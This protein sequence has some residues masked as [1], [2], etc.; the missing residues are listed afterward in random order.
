MSNPPFPRPRR[1]APRPPAEVPAQVATLTR[2][3]VL[4]EPD[5]P[6]GDEQAAHALVADHA[7][8]RVGDR[9][10]LDRRSRSLVALATLVGRSDDELLADQVRAARSHGLT[11]PEIEEALLQTAVH[12]G[13]ADAAT[14]VRIARAALEEERP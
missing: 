5:D 2:H 3:H 9:P 1:A 14:A 8:G 6:S 12:V 10:G 4:G 11:G 7:A 13:V